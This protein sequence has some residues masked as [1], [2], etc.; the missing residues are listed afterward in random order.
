MEKVIKKLR[1]AASVGL[2]GAVIGSFVGMTPLAAGVAVAGSE[3]AGLFVGLLIGAVV[4]L[5]YKQG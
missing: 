1:I 2:V 5:V 3:E 4:A